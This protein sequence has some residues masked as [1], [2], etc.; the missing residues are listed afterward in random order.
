MQKQLNFEFKKEDL[1]CGSLYEFVQ[2]YIMPHD[3]SIEFITL[4]ENGKKSFMFRSN[5]FLSKFCI[6]MRK[7]E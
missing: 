7:Q 5:K 4:P 6:D 2:K 1:G 3:D